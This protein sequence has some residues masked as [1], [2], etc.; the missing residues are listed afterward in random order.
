MIID[1]EIKVQNDDTV[2]DVKNECSA[3]TKSES[4]DQMSGIVRPW[5]QSLAIDLN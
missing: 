5:V 4:I 3:E 2:K 1:F